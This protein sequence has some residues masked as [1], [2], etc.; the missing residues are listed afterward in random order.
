[1]GDVREAVASW[2]TVTKT[3]RYYCIGPTDDAAIREVWFILHGF[4]QLAATFA[5]YFGDLDDG[6]RLIVAPEALNRYYLVPANG[7]PAAERPVG[8]TWMTREDRDHE[9]ADYVNYLDTL[10]AEIARRVPSP[11][12]IVVVGFSQGAATAARWAA[13]GTARLDRL[14][15][16]G[17]MLPPGDRSRRGASGAAWHSVDVRA[18]EERP[19]CHA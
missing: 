5:T 7:V 8:A 1:M 9:I 2:L 3:A 18:R 19:V 6:T 13:R 10:H 15:L 16:W 14:V 17:G 12:R 4:G 11:D